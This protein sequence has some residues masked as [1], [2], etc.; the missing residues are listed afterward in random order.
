MIYIINT[1]A[2]TAIPPSATNSPRIWLASPVMVDDFVGA[3]L[4]AEEEE[5]IAAVELASEADGVA[6]ELL[7]AAT[8]GPKRLPCCCAGEALFEVSTTLALKMVRVSDTLD[9]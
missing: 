6:P 4:T 5:V 3:E 9:L 1:A 8:K 2:A 7:V